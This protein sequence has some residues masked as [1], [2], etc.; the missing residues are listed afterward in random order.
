M[1]GIAEALAAVGNQTGAGSLWE[2]RL[3]LE[4]GRATSLQGVVQVFGRA[5][6]DAEA[7][8]LASVSE[9]VTPIKQ[10]CSPQ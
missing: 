9:S 7:S 5:A 6:A 4:E 1:L 3:V 8:V 10:A 2:D